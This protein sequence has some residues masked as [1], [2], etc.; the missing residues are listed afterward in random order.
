[1]NTN[2]VGDITNFMVTATSQLFGTTTR[3][4]VLLAVRVLE[5]TWASE[6]A[7]ALGLRLFSIQNALRSLEREGVVVIRNV[8]RTR[9]VSLNARYVA[10]NELD[11]LLWALVKSDV[12]LQKKLATLRRRPRRTGKDGVL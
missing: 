1:M 9:V 8:G 3:T 11:A 12:V 4:E 2:I 7:S 5:E 6:L 10:A